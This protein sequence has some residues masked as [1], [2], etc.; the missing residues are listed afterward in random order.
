MQL[1]GRVV[2]GTG[3]G[4]PRN[5]GRDASIERLFGTR[6]WYRIWEAVSET[7]VDKEKNPAMSGAFVKSG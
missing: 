4:S 5:T 1:L 2:R 3:V 7:A 6:W